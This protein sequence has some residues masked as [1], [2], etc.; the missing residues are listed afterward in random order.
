ML[1][2]FCG[3]ICDLIGVN[4]TELL[5][6]KDCPC[7]TTA[8]ILVYLATIPPAPHPKQLIWHGDSFYHH[9]QQK[10]KQQWH[11]FLKISWI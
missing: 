10:G 2:C 4:M 1:P 8:I 9:H 11:S 7:H 3:D 6:N 5:T